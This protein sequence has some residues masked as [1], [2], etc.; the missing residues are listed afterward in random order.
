MTIGVSVLVGVALYLLAKNLTIV[1]IASEQ[2]QAVPFVFSM[3]IYGLDANNQMQLRRAKAVARKSDG[4]TAVVESI[5]LLEWDQYS[6]KVTFLNGKSFSV[7]DAI[8][9][10]STWPPMA[11]SDLAHIKTLLTNPRTDCA[12]SGTVVGSDIVLGEPVTALR[13]S[14]NLQRGSTAT[15]G[16]SSTCCGGKLVAGERVTTWLAPRLGCE[17]LQYQVEVIHPDGSLET[18]VEGRPIRLDYQ[19]PD[20]HWFNEPASYTEAAP[21]VIQSKLLEQMGIQEDDSLQGEG[22][23]LDKGY[24]GH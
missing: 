19:E 9:M 11:V 14:I 3:D 16:T 15:P 18:A 24:Q 4:T 2:V 7:V 13:L 10:K 17:S 21:S 8:Q 6:R 1:T 23:N 20:A 5:G 22:Q 12:Y